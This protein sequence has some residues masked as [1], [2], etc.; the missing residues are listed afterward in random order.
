MKKQAPMIGKTIGK[1]K[2]LEEIG[3]GGMG[4]VYKGLQISLNRTVALKMLPPQMA[5]SEDFLERFQR[6]ARVLAR[7][8]HKNI[9]HIYDLEELEEAYFIIMEY[10]EGRSLAEIIASEAPLSMDFT[11]KVAIGVASALSAAHR[12][13]IIH[14]DIKPENIMVNTYDEVKVMDFGIARAADESFKTR[15]GIRLGTPEYMSPEQAKGLSVDAQSDIYSLGIVLYEMVTGQVPF[16]GEDSIA[17]ALKHIQ[18]PVKSPTLINPHIIPDIERTIIKA[19]GKEKNSRFKTADEFYLA[20][21][22]IYISEEKEKR[23]E[24]P[25][26]FQYCPECG[27]AL[28]KD[29]LRCPQCSLVVRRVCP[30]CHEA[31]DA[32]YK[33]CPH[34]SKDLPS[35]TPEN[36]PKTI[37]EEAISKEYPSPKREEI[38]KIFKFPFLK[39]I[40]YKIQFKV[41]EL[42]KKPKAA[43]ILG[44]TFI[45]LLAI[46]VAV[47]QI[48]KS[49]PKT[50]EVGPL[51]GSPGLT[52]SPEKPTPKSQKYQ[53]PIIMEKEPGAEELEEMVQQAKDYFETG[54]Y[55]LCIAQ[56]KETLKWKPESSEY[57]IFK[58]RAEKTKPMVKKYIDKA[59]SAL[60]NQKYH[61]CVIEC[62]KVLAISSRHVQATEL[63]SLAK[64]QIPQPA[65]ESK[66]QPGSIQKA[67]ITREEKEKIQAIIARQKQGMQDENI[68]L[69]LQD[70]IPGLQSEVQGNA[71]KFFAQNDILTVT[72]SN[73]KIHIKIGEAEVNF[74]STIVYSPMNTDEQKRQTVPVNWGLRKIGSFWKIVKF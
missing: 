18:E 65:Q 62:E 8:A 37:V 61:I 16:T 68:S 58:E 30:Y 47:T 56:L 55:D 2:I 15:A 42:L 59:R 46:L 12:A 54:A 73:V 23:V 32:V 7:L 38:K 63:L 13:G 27:F 29:F 41:P 5:I 25:L 28:K 31:F 70:V 4:V 33:V 26:A 48:T 50:N 3:R 49:R 51:S 69:L 19:L 10:I 21:E 24:K 35:L 52:S 39:R 66:F 74:R 72:F 43:A 67:D 45:I 20:F 71:E 14:R 53:P 34:C 6:E 36:V 57:R 1:Y 22:K 17:I 64:A 60:H 44:G 40:P 11:R 9:V